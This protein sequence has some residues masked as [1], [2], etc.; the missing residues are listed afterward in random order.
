MS[1]TSRLTES[2][3]RLR[4]RMTST[5]V[6]E[7]ASIPVD[8]RDGLAPV[9]VSDGRAAA[10]LVGD[11]LGRTVARVALPAVA[12]SLLMTL[13]AS[14]DAFWVGTRLGSDGL[15]AVS[16]SLFWIWMMVALAEMVGVGLTA[17]AARR[18]GEG[19]PA[20]AAG[21]AGDALL[22]TLAIGIVVALGGLVALPGLFRV[23][24]TPA[25]VT[26]LGT[27]YLG[28]YLVGI[29]LIYGFFAIDATFRAAGDTRTPFV[30][31]A[32]SV[33]ITLVLD[34]ALMLGWG[35][36]PRLGIPGAAIA[37]VL[38]R[39]AAF[40]M[41]TLLAVRRKLLRVRWPEASSV[42]AV[43]RVGLPTAVTGVVFSIIYIA[44]TR[45]ATQFGT[46][47]LAALGIGHRVESWLF[48]I[49]VGFGAATAAIVGQNL[50]AGEIKR[51]E[52]AG[53]LSVGLCSGLG[54]VACTADLLFAPTLARL[55]TNDPAV[56]L[57]AARYLRIA[58]IS[59][60]GICAEIVLEGA[61]GGAGETLPPMIASSAFTA[62]RVPIVP[63][64]AMRWGSAGIWWTICLTAIGRA[65]SMIALWRWGRW[66]NRSL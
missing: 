58:A 45:T 61:L 60:L 38:T 6:V 14:V 17:V 47:A 31:L 50:G 15:A 7:P 21:V 33:A 46:P 41:G 53:W 29:P 26:A 24:Q 66:K 32:V 62:A 55:F 43:C 9:G 59:Q 65:L 12:S 16:T 48:M 18:H 19:R 8:P 13:F 22:F 54:L 36:F 30:L 57:E 49:G 11:S 34:P 25:A 28:T 56:I 63:L 64:A 44:V 20:A 39:G 52:R 1:R 35:P 4:R 5:D 27:R 42:I 40:A 37:T 3:W 51:A 2:R 23:M 10:H